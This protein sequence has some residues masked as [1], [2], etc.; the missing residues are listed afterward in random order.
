MRK[1]AALVNGLPVTARLHF[2]ETGGWGTTEH[3][4]ALIADRVED[5]RHS[6][7]AASP[8]KFKYV[9]PRRVRRPGDPEPEKHGVSIRQ[10]F[11]M[12]NG[13]GAGG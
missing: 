12:Q 9:E 4:L 11:A 13:G 7:L 3:L 6:T 10:F 2:P 5:S 8:L 1:L